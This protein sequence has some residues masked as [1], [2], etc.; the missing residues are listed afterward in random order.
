MHYF[1]AI[2]RNEETLHFAKNYKN[3]GLV[4]SDVEERMKKLS[5]SVEQSPICI[6]LT[7]C[8]GL[9]EYV[10]PRFEE[11]TGYRSEEVI[12]KKPGIVSSGHHPKE[13]YE[14]LWREI[15]AG[16]QWRGVFHNRKKDGSIYY[17]SAIIT[18]IQ[19][20]EGEITNFM[21]I[22]ED[23]TARLIAEQKLKESI[24]TRD[25]LFSI[26]S[27]DLRGPVGNMPPLLDIIINNMVENEE[28]KTEL[29]VSMRKAAYN[30]KDLLEN[31]LKWAS[32]QTGSISLSPV[33]FNIRD[34]VNWETELYSSLAAEKKIDIE[35]NIPND[36]TAYAD[37]E[38]FRL[39]VRNLI[40]NAIKYSYLKSKITLNAVPRDEMVLISVSDNGVGMTKETLMRIFESDSFISTYGTK[41]EKG[42]GL[43]INLC[44]EFVRKNGGEIYAESEPGKGTKF[45]FTLNKREVANLE[46][47]SSG[48]IPENV[49]E[50]VLEGRRILFV[51][52][53][54]FNKVYTSALF[55]KWGVDYVMASNGEDGI[56]YLKNS[57]F[58]II[59]MDLEMPVIDGMEAVKFIREEMNLKLP[60]VAISANDSQKYIRRVLKSGFNNYIIKPYSEDHLLDVVVKL[61]QSHKPKPS[62]NTEPIKEE[63]VADLN[64]LK[65]LFSGENAAIAEMLQKFLDIVPT[66]YQS[67]LEAYDKSDMKML[68]SH[69]HKLKSSIAIVAGSKAVENINLV[70]SLS[71]KDTGGVVLK[72]EMK[73]LTKWFP[74]LCKELK[75]ELKFM[76]N[77]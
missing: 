67:A 55:G 54:E 24:F 38:S 8:N 18:P 28:A 9:I 61:L 42:T 21:G 6:L 11:L 48:K 60:I 71:E 32:L 74:Q 57:T 73:I 7:D 49:S 36:L 53:D 19:N 29:L 43:G 12:G 25:K 2:M 56:K 50:K 5:L 15:K 13:F 20:E 77:V 37:V 64:K 27:H 65:Q 16:R 31:L 62:S 35:N 26:I 10:N 41:N 33:D 14:E 66:Y 39:I 47:F 51:D 70:N 63:R 30:I 75:Q 58:D 68:H 59:L 45:S 22:K 44:K 72:R 3:A 46:S 69:I 34:A 4:P 40:G 17:E 52:D 23:I 1:K 76:K